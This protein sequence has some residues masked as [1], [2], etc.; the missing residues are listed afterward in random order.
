[1]IDDSERR[2]VARMLRAL[3]C[4]GIQESLI[5]AYLNELGI[6]GYEDWVGIEHRLADL[7]EPDGKGIESEASKPVESDGISRDALLALAD[8]MEQI[9]DGN[10]L[11]GMM[12]IGRARSWADSIRGALGVEHAES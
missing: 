4:S 7:I 8:E 10:R 12:S 6:Y 5:C 11:T 1:M 3:D 2:E 9:A